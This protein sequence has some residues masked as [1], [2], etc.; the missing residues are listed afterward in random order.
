MKTLLLLLPIF[1]FL[2]ITNASTDVTCWDDCLKSG[3]T[4]TNLEKGQETDFGCYRDGCE[5]SGWIIGTRPKSYTQ[6]KAGGCFQEGWY[7]LSSETQTLE[8]Q[9]V[10]RTH[11]DQQIGKADCLKFGWITYN[12]TGQE[13]LTTCYEDSCATKG[14]LVK[15]PTQQTQHISCKK[16]GCFKTGWKQADY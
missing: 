13:S 16:G 11:Q 15:L 6:C 5:K 1:F 7:Q 14:W 2:Q 3:W 8:K 4:S 10:C 12:T 9:I